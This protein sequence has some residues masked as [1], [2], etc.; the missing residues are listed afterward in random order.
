MMPTVITQLSCTINQPGT[1]VLASDLNFDSADGYA[2]NIT[3]DDVILDL[4]GHTLSNDGGGIGTFATGISAVDCDNVTI[5]NGRITGFLY[6]I[7]LEDLS[8]NNDATGGHTVTD[9]VIESATF[10]GIVVEGHN[11]TVSDN[12]IH[13]IG[14]TSVFTNAFAIGIESFGP[15]ALISG[16]DIEEVHA[17]GAGEAVGI[18]VSDDGL[19]VNVLDNT[20]INST[21]HDHSFGFWIGSYGDVELAGNSVADFATGM[22]WP[23]DSAGTFHDNTLVSTY[24]P[25][26]ISGVDVSATGTNSIYGSSGNDSYVGFSGDDF[27]DGGAGDDRLFGAAGDDHLSG[28]AGCDVL[29]GGPGNDHL[30]GG[31]GIDFAVVTG[32]EADYTLTYDASVNDYDLVDASPIPTD[33]ADTLTS[34]EFVKF[35]DDLVALPYDGTLVRSDDASGTEPWTW[36]GSLYDAGGL[37]KYDATSLD[38]GSLSLVQYDTDSTQGWSSKSFNFGSSLEL[39]S[40]TTRLRDGSTLSTDYDQSFEFSWAYVTSSFD[41][42]GRLDTVTRVMDDGSKVFVDWDQA[43][44]QPWTVSTTTYNSQGLLD[45]VQQILD[46]G[47]TY[48]T[49]YDDKSVFSWKT[50]VSEYNAQDKLSYVS[51]YSDP[52]NVFVTAYNA[53]G[54]QPWTKAITGYDSQGR[55]DYVT[56]LFDDGTSSYTDY[57]QANQSDLAY[58]VYTFDQHNQLLHTYLSYDNGA[59]YIA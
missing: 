44:I 33:G 18:S 16:N 47:R 41:S 35:A 37:L 5:T 3:C 36:Q 59:V 58:G 8:T 2:I 50:A 38:D 13:D 19:G 12:T 49:D 25:Y 48:V 14:G 17:S 28:G 46:D 39:D 53:G 11:N 29:V 23:T 56:I 40:E 45:N 55:M 9:M 7:R 51:I 10:R 4:N 24:L 20:I 15:G 1:Y 54:E 31:D 21:T 22:A 32:P 26:T 30:A 34:I 43:S 27:I 6:P 57:D 42:E 52:G